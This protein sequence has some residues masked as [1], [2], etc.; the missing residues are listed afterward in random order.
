[1]ERRSGSNLPAAFHLSWISLFEETGDPVSGPTDLRTAGN[2]SIMRLAPIPLFYAN[3]PDKAMEMSG[4]SSITTHETKTCID[5]CRY[6]GGLIVEAVKGV[7]RKELL[8]LRYR[9]DGLS[10]KEGYEAI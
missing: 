3:F 10:W 2:G 9:P 6:F 4:K 7:S 8:S 1:M 5:A